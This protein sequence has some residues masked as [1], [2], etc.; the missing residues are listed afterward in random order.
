MVLILYDLISTNI[1]DSR[2]S[3]A[4]W[5]ELLLDLAFHYEIV[6]NLVFVM[7]VLKLW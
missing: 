6:F 2:H 1:C 5:P 3:C 7:A 4:R